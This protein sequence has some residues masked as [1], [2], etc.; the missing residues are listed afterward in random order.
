MVVGHGTE[1]RHKKLHKRSFA[2]PP[3]NSSS[4]F[5]R[6][7]GIKV[8]IFVDTVGQTQYSIAGGTLRLS[9]V[10]ILCA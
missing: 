1:L 7:R 3:L 9:R 4:V 10:E 2:P 8:D 5:S 6:H